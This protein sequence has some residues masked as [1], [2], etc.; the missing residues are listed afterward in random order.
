MFFGFAKYGKPEMFQV[1]SADIT[2]SVSRTWERTNNRDS[3][4]TAYLSGVGFNQN[5]L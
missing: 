4:L 2:T 3:E 1:Y 5:H